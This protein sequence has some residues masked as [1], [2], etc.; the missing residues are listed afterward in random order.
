MKLRKPSYPD[1]VGTAVYFYTHAG[2][3]QTAIETAVSVIRKAGK[4]EH[5]ALADDPV[6]QALTGHMGDWVIESLL[7]GAWMREYHQWEKATKDYLDG[8]HARN[9]SSKV[10]WKGK[11]P[12]I[13]NPSH[14]HRVRAQLVLFEASVPA[15]V[16]AA[17]DSTRDLVNLD[18]HETD[19]FIGQADYRALM[20]AVL[21]F[22]EA[23]AE[24]EEFTPP[25]R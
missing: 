22:W 12:G 25:A 19:H 24:Q 23:L 8:N 10:K 13:S 1:V 3:R 9:G 11:L 5:D 6:W 14:M 15:D 18:K 2:H 4:R 20:Q 7:Q 16:L 21:A 17:I